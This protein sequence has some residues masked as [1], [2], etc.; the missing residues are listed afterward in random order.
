MR[1]AGRCGGAD[2]NVPEP[3]GTLFRNVP[4]GPTTSATLHH[5]SYTE[6]K[7]QTATRRDESYLGQMKRSVR[8]PRGSRVRKLRLNCRFKRS[9]DCVVWACK[10]APRRRNGA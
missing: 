1:R 8:L 2:R 6:H 4:I 7:L 5:I 3:A 10:T 9:G